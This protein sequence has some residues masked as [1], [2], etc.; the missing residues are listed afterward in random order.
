MCNKLYSVSN[1]VINENEYDGFNDL[2]VITK[3]LID[4]L[5]KIIKNPEKY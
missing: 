2:Q 1:L 3:K 5:R 4:D